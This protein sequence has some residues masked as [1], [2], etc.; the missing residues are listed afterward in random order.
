MTHHLRCIGFFALASL[1]F[2]QDRP[3]LGQAV[4]QPKASERAMDKILTA[5]FYPPNGY[6]DPAMK[7]GREATEKAMIA[8]YD[9]LRAKYDAAHDKA[10]AQVEAI[11]SM[12]SDSPMDFTQ[13]KEELRRSID[14]I[15]KAKRD[16]DTKTLGP[17]S[18]F[19]DIPRLTN[20]DMGAVF[21]EAKAHL[22]AKGV[23]GKL[24]ALK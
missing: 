18:G 12:K 22:I 15:L 21:A 4:Q 19:Y 8:H 2:A 9:G 16:Y 23:T 20:E 5:R 7:M 17:Q 14:D 1:L 11:A 3:K 24:D 10:V 13:V 6:Q